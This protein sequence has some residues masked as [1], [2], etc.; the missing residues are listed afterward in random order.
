MRA[1]KWS[2]SSPYNTVNIRRGQA[3][4]LE[5]DMVRGKPRLAILSTPKTRRARHPDLPETETRFR[6]APNKVRGRRHVRTSARKYARPIKA[7]TAMYPGS[8]QNPPHPYHDPHATPVRHMSCGFGG[9]DR[10][11]ARRSRSQGL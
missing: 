5:I 7:R 9:L 1:E 10:R 8:C 4:N 6:P 3:D 2:L 11:N